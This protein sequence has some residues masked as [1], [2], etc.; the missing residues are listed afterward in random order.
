M[1]RRIEQY[2][3]NAFIIEGRFLL[4]HKTE[5][6]LTRIHPPTGGTYQTLIS[7]VGAD[8]D[9]IDS[10]NSFKLVI[11]E[12]PQ[13]PAPSSVT[14]PVVPRNA[15]QGELSGPQNKTDLSHPLRMTFK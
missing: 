6:H 10:I 13:L 5:A 11:S 1:E 7:F 9:R 8:V 12:S 14:I 2:C 15:S 3:V 4:N